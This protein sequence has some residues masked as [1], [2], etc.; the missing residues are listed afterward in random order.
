MKRWE[1]LPGLLGGGP[2]GDVHTFPP[3]SPPPAEGG[4]GLEWLKVVPRH[5]T[6]LVR[7]LPSQLV[8]P[9]ARPLRGPQAGLGRGRRMGPGHAR[10]R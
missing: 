2:G 1:A 9:R 4:H 5:L 6:G 10:D 3:H 8:W 7:L